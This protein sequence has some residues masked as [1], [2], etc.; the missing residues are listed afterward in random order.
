MHQSK[1]RSSQT[2][3]GQVNMQVTTDKERLAQSEEL[4]RPQF[5]DDFVSWHTRKKSLTA[6]P[7]QQQ[8]GFVSKMKAQ[9]MLTRQF[10]WEQRF[11]EFD[12][13][14]WAGVYSLIKKSHYHQTG[15]TLMRLPELK[16]RHFP[17]NMD[18]EGSECITRPV[19]VDATSAPST[20]ECFLCTTWG[21][22]L[23]CPILVR[24][25]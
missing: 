7:A 14:C 20:R 19:S 18:A 4:L 13:I 8:T 15:G 21:G 17:S 1:R 16:N 9:D 23:G 5:G 10:C 6:G 3:P 11:S 22:T 24:A 2:M 12:G 25:L